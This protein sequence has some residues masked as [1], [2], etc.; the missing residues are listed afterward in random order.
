LQAEIEQQLSAKATPNSRNG[1]NSK[2][3]KSSVGAFE[4][5]APRDREGSFEPQI[6]KKKIKLNFEMNQ[7]KK[8]YLCLYQE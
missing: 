6:I 5:D 1:Y 2:T 8:L 7:I 4:L 3:V